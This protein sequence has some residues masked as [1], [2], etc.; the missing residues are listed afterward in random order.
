MSKSV[1]YSHIA[2]DYAK[3]RDIHPGA[4]GSLISV[5]D[6]DRDS[7]VLEVGCGTGN[8]ILAV[9]SLL[10]SSCWGIDP[11]RAMLSEA[12]RRPGRV[13]FRQ[14]QAGAL[15][16]ESGFFDLVFCVDVIHHVN[17]RQAYFDEAYRVLKSGGKVCT[18]TDSEWIIQHRQPLTTYFPETVE[19][20]LKRY[21]RI[22]DLRKF[23]EQAGFSQMDEEMVE[24][25]YQLVDSKAYR[26]KAFSALHLI[27]QAAFERGLERMEEDLHSGPIPCVSRYVLLWGT[28]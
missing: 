18:V 12:A 13:Q 5:S 8:Y 20:E 14:G 2:S 19:I 27:P 15:D 7:N 25:A 10:G 22:S 26:Q 17:D 24:F 23:M 9:G 1:D 28:K 4:L 6:I 21:P 16:F 11:S 3:H